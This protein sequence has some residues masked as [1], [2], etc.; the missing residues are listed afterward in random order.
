MG[1]YERMVD[2]VIVRILVFERSR[3]AV[4]NEDFRLIV[5][6]DAVD[7]RYPAYATRGAWMSMVNAR[8]DV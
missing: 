8:F 2:D 5:A 7:L 1:F 3:V 6:E 4:V